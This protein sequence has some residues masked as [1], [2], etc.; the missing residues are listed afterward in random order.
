MTIPAPTDRRDAPHIAGP[1]RTREVPAAGPES[2]SG[3][4]SVTRV[5]EPVGWVRRLGRQLWVYRRNTVL[6]FGGALLATLVTAAVPLV[7]RQVIDNVVVTHRH[8]LTPYLIM[9][10]ASGVVIFGAA[11]LRRFYGGKLSLDVQYDLRDAVFGTIERLDG[12]RQD[13]LS[14]GQVVSRAISDVTVIQG[15]LSYLPMVSGNLVLFIVSLVAMAWLSPVLTLIALAMGPALFLLGAR[16]RH[17]VFPATWAAQQQAGEVAGAV[18]EAVAGVRVV[19][20]FGQEPRELDRVS[21]HARVLFALR[22]RAVRITSRFGAAMQAVPALGQVAVLALGGWLALTDRITLGTFLA[23]STYLG[24]L[25]G[26]TRTLAGLLTVGQQ[27]R[28]STVRIFEIIDSR[29]T[30]TDP[31]DAVTLD[32]ARG[33][34][35]LD[36]VTFGYQPDRPVLRDVS[37]RIEPGETVALVGTSGSGKSTISQLL[38]RFYDPQAG[39]V[40]LDGHDVRTLTLRSLRAQLGMVFED[41]FLYSDTVRANIGYGRPDATEDQVV[42]AARAAQADG[43]IRDLPDGYDT[44]VGEQGLTLSGGQRQ[45]VALARALLSDPTVLILDDATSAVDAGIEAR[46]HAT[47]AEVMRGRTTLLIAH[48]RSTLHLAD[49]IAVLDAGRIVDLGTE[50]E[51][52]VRSPLFRALLAGPGDTLADQTPPDPAGTASRTDAAGTAAAVPQAAVPQAA[53]PQ[54]AVTQ[55]EVAGS[56]ASEAA[57]PG[58]AVGSGLVVPAVLGSRIGGQGSAAG[59]HRNGAV[60]A[61]TGGGRGFGG[62]SGGVGGGAR[63]FGG[64]GGRAIGGGGAFGDVPATPELLAKVDA[65]PPAEDDPSVDQAA[66]AAPDP[67]FTLGRLLA[68][69]RVPLVVGLLLVALDAVAGLALPALVRHAVDAGVTN[70]ARGVLFGTAG[71]ALAITLADWVTQVYQTRVT[72]RM[73]ER[74]LYVLRVKTFAHLQRLGLD[75]YERELAG[76]IMTRMTTDVDALSTFLQTGLTTAIV[77]LL[78]FFGVLIA[79][80]ILDAELALVV[81]AVLPVLIVATVIFR[82]RSSIAYTEARERV[83]AVNASLQENLTGLRVAQAFGREE[84]NQERFRAL[85]DSYRRSRMRAQQMIAFY[86][87]GVEFLSRIAGALVL[88]IGAH[89]AVHGDLSAGALLAFLLYVNLFFS[90]VQQLS[91]VFDGYQQA[92]VGLRRLSDLLRTPTSTPPAERPRAVGRLTGE[93]VLDDVT[94]AYT[95]AARPGAGGPAGGTRTAGNAVDGV[96]LRIAPGETVAF[97]GETGAGKSTMLKLIARYYD[98]TSGAVRIDGVDVREFDLSAFRRRLGVVPQEPFVFSGTV[99]D[100]IAY[101]RPDASDEQVRAAAHAVGAEAFIEALPDGYDQAVGERGRG[102]SAGQRQL[103]A[104]ARAELADPDILLFDEATAALDLATEAAVTAAAEAVTTRRTTIVIAHRL[105][106]AAR[107]DRVVVMADGRIAEQGTH[108]ELVRAGGAYARLWAAF[109]AGADPTAAPGTDAIPDT[110]AI[111]DT[112][113]IPDTGAM[114]DTG[115]V[116]APPDAEHSAVS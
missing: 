81:V 110:D 72:G 74:L 99:R 44:V 102:L 112:D 71:I 87:P 14:T 68:W 15:L 83:S 56:A 55:A 21:A 103:L 34:V 37:L 51:L 86:F 9:L 23:F 22:M 13:A 108:A 88:G 98:V 7:E 32:S 80:L 31:P 11:F 54:A 95:V 16:A 82:R 53:V 73:G 77:S 33:L 10:L 52:A 65:L 3:P 64:P 28:A 49:R 101:A 114:P 48:R 6:A 76:R 17:T 2:A 25:I 30:I 43:F 92:M 12:A 58:P 113:A 104:L 4:E 1:P 69:V 50:D 19:K 29:S 63:A 67:G 91:Q 90:P 97:V 106:T 35:E 45:R 38:P 36:G 107:A 39:A 46:I 111:S 109:T 85:A 115:A 70:H 100:A 27:A 61:G 42:A 62:G 20:G 84:V 40:R 18:E 24:A 89:L 105:T 60:A 75:Y 116:P 78:S 79:L 96:S 66:A 57:V 8:S 93:V 94:F 41:S 5:A 47:L 26:P 59:G